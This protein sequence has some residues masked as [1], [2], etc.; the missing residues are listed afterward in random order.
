MSFTQEER[1]IAIETPLGTDAL[2]LTSVEGVEEISRLFTYQVRMISE[3][4]RIEPAEIVGKNVTIVLRDVDDEPRYLNGFVRHFVNRGRGDRATTYYAE[5]VPWLWFL[6]RRSDCRIFQNMTVPQIVQEVFTKLGFT[7]FDVAGLSGSYE[8]RDYVVQYAE[9]DFNFVSRLMENEGIFYF[10]RHDLGRHVLVMADS[11]AAYRPCK[12][13]SVRYSGPLSFSEVDD[14]LS[15]WE[16]RFEFRSGKVAMGDYNFETP[17][18]PVPSRE[19][20]LMPVP[21]SSRFELYE[22]PG[23]FLERGGAD[24]RARLRMQEEEASHDIVV[25]AGKCRSF[26]P[27]CTFKVE[28]HHQPEE[29]G[30]TYLITKV[31]HRAAAGDYTPGGGGSPEG[32]GNEF[33]CIPASV[34]FRPARI[35]PKSIVRGPQ[36]AKVV[37]PQ[38]EEVHCD[39]YGRI[40]VQFPWDRYAPGDDRSS[41]WV[42]VSQAWAGQGYGGIN[43]PR[44]GQEVVVDFLEGDPDRPII[45]GRVY[46][47]AQMQSDTLPESTIAGPTGP[48]PIPEMQG[49]AGGLPAAK[50]RSTFKTCTTPGGGGANELCF[51]DTGG[52]ELMYINASKDLV[53]TVCNNEKHNVGNDQELSVGK[54]QKMFVGVNR[55]T[56]VG[57]NETMRVCGNQQET[58]LGSRTTTIGVN[59]TET[60]GSAKS[61]TIGT[62]HTETVGAAK[63]E[64][65]G[66]AKALSIGGAYQISVGGAMNHTVGGALALEVGGVLAEIVGGTR[67]IDVRGDQKQAVKGKQEESA[68]EI[69]LTAK[70]KLT[71]VCGGSKIELTP[72]M[73]EI[74]SPFVRINC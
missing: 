12:H 42:R 9:S 58:V 49:R 1:R 63:T 6:T 56:H 15:A 13:A 43:I 44:I 60:V 36:T 70:T 27:G 3:R 22:Y 61:V 11:T 5:V 35:T 40:K 66:G 64:T 20:T 37:G 69:T 72:A 18:S 34:T 33:E 46:N 23:G 17:Q 14:D 74:K 30:R 4:E 50:A 62:N 53:I 7:D 38:G 31:M 65:I 73:I 29:E 68:T 51:D 67:D 28:A 10:F 52:K 26:S 16:H 24:R 47:A 54:N 21:D 32:Y 55:E 25:G 39:K 59:D 57:G 19:R 2:L 8:K 41:C 48:K 45:T 71:L